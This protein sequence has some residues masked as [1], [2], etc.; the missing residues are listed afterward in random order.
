MSAKPKPAPTITRSEWLIQQ[1]NPLRHTLTELGGGHTTEAGQFDQ[2][3]AILSGPLGQL[4]RELTDGNGYSLDG[5]LAACVRAIRAYNHGEA[6]HRAR[7]VLRGVE[8][9]ATGQDSDYA[10]YRQLR[11]YEL[12]E[13]AP[14]PAPAEIVQPTTDEQTAS[15]VLHNLGTQRCTCSPEQTVKIDGDSVSI[16][17]THAKT[18]LQRSLIERQ[19]SAQGK[20]LE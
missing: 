13:D 6:I 18:C 14:P 15:S 17:V 1:L 11:S 7:H 10:E 12:H 5:E 16:Q 8:A 3:A 2:Y 4:P 19:L 9:V 20:T